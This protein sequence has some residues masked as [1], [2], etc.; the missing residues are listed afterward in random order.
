MNNINRD[1][2]VMFNQELMSPQAIEQQVELL[3]ELLF[4]VEKMDNLAIAHEVLD[5]N[6]YKLINNHAVVKETI[7]KQ[8]LNAFVFLNCKN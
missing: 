3:H 8:D 5:L 7:R 1:L 6:K 2:L 4:D